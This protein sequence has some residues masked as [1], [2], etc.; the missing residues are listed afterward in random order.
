MSDHNRA[1]KCLLLGMLVVLLGAI[2]SYQIA[3]AA[4]APH[5]IP[6]MRPRYEGQSALAR[7]TLTPEPTAG[8]QRPSLCE[9]PPTGSA[10]PAGCTE[11]SAEVCLRLSVDPGVAPASIATYQLVAQNS[12]PGDAARIR[13]TLPFAPDVQTPLDAAFS[14][15]GAWVSA[16]LTDA[17][18]LRLESLTRDQAITATLRLRTNP[19]APLG[20]DLTA[21]AQLDWSGSAT[22]AGVSNR[23]PLVVGHTG[24]RSA[25][26]TLEL[27]PAAGPPTTMFVAAY[28]G[29]ASY[30]RVSLWYHRPDGSVVGLREVRA[31]GQGQIV[32]RLAASAFGSGGYSL[33]AYGQCS[34][35][36]A[37]GSFSIA[38]PQPTAS[39]AS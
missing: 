25:T 1:A 23:V 20:R 5:P 3:T 24:P 26:A 17:I 4:R 29:F 10:L 30:E 9:R 38:E 18:E 7:A 32:Y 21:R 12:G 37:V 31:D 2:E 34:Q 33:V 39:P 35:V 14:D 36:T 28:T 27:L 16:V 6:H 11:Q 8:P 19:D 15:S 22:S 13:I